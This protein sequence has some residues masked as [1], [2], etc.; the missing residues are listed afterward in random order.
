MKRASLGT[1]ISPC[2]LA[3]TAM[4]WRQFLQAQAAIMLAADFFHIDGAVTLQRL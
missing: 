3:C 4:S 2:L 1:G